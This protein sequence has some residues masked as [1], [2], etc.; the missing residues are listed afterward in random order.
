[1]EIFEGKIPN[2]VGNFTNSEIVQ[3]SGGGV[4]TNMKLVVLGEGYG[5]LSGGR[6]SH[7][8]GDYFAQGK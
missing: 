7:R 2:I 6:G 5:R 4:V 1:M 3:F 8:R